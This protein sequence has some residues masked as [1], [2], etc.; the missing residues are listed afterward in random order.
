MPAIDPV[1]R[2]A[3]MSRGLGSRL[4]ALLAVGLVV[5]GCG[6]VPNDPSVAPGEPFACIETSPDICQQTLRDA[7]AN[8][9]PGTTVVALRVVCTSPP[10]TDQGGEVSVEVAYSNGRRDSYSSAWA[11][12]AE[13][14]AAPE[15]TELP[16]EP[17]CG[18]IPREQCLEFAASAFTGVDPSTVVSIVLRCTTTCTTASGDGET[19][20]TFDDGTSITNGWSY[21]GATP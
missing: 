2:L 21:E 8:A 9:D 5:A 12:A 11:G 14:E 20:V 18:G 6:I 1:A 13:P 19:L 16:I 17:V 3:R 4:G 7:Q 15:P 10:C